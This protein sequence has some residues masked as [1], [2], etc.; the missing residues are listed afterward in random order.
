MI[1]VYKNFN[2]AISVI[3]AAYNRA[4]YIERS[5]NSVIEQIFK[6]W[7]L[8]IVDDGSSDDTF[9][10]VNGYLNRYENV[11]YL[12]HSNRKL[13]LTRN[14][15]IKCSAGRYITFLDTDDLYEPEHLLRRFEFMESHPGVDLLHGGARIIGNP[16]VK[17]KND[18]TKMI[19]LNECAIGG[20]F[21][22]KREV[23]TKL[24]GFRDIPY[25]E[26]SEFFERASEVFKTEKTDFPSYVY[27]RDS[28]DGICN[29]I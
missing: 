1:S 27:Y 12:R 16:Y 19:H 2:P 24:G 3:M 17:D 20:T 9:S 4:G 21:F 22:G 23:F 5:V 10:V 11:R 13:P 28:E 7:E 25:S 29:N 8:I 14:A 18:L 15:G 6:D 26:D